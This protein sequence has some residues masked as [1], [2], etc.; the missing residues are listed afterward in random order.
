M[1]MLLKPSLLLL[2]VTLCYF[3]ASA[4]DTKKTIAGTVTDSSGAPVV[5]ATIHEKGKNNFTTSDGT[6]HFTISVMPNAV[7]EITYTGFETVNVGTD[8]ATPT[9]V[10][11]SGGGQIEQVVV[12]ALGIKR[13]R[14]SLGYSVQEVKGE[15]L[16]EIKDPNLTNELT[17][18]VAGLQIV[19]SGNGPAGS[20]QIRLRGN[21]S[22]TNI[23]QPLIVVDGMPISNITGRSGVNNTNDFY[24]PSLDNGNGLSDGIDESGCCGAVSVSNVDR[25]SP[26]QIDDDVG[27]HAHCNEARACEAA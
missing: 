3:S 23:S 25:G 6:G 19:R 26:S 18:Q 14:K 24:N 9:I 4:Q 7:L 21:N 5:A 27:V 15:T 13:Q 20:S 2:A 11:R 8:N 22:L 12:T 16:N 17:G 1:K 10:M